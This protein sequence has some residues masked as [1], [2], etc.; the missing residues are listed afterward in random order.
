MTPNELSTL[1]RFVTSNNSFCAALNGE[2]SIPLDFPLKIELIIYYLTINKKNLLS[3]NIPYKEVLLSLI[4]NQ[5]FVFEDDILLVEGTPFTIELLT[6]LI[7]QIESSKIEEANNKIVYLT[8]INREPKIHRAQT[9]QVIQFKEA[10]RRVFYTSLE[11]S[12]IFERTAKVNQDTISYINRTKSD[13]IALVNDI[14]LKAL[15]NELEGYNSKYLK[16]IAAYLRLYPFLVYLSGKKTIPYEEIRLPQ[17]QI[18]LR[19]TTFNNPLISEIEKEISTIMSREERLLLKRDVLE[20]SKNFNGKVIT[21][22]E[23]EL[24]DIEKE[25]ANLFYGLFL[26]RNSPELYNE[27]LLTYLIKAFQAGTIDINRFVVNPIIKSFFV[28]NETAEFHCSMRLETLS[29]LINPEE[30]LPLLIEQKALKLDV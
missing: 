16:V 25:K 24:L 5:N 15:S 1:K 14:V 13:Y 28:N 7:N 27:N 2:S 18:G 29:N 12:I 23:Q 30:L 11:S 4:E 8:N 20:S 17:G 21:I 22:L 9:G 3:S 6:S 19:K 26:L 10:S